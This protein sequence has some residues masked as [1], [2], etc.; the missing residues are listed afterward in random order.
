[1]SF[2][3]VIL[4]D[5][6]YATVAGRPLTGSKI[7]HG[8]KLPDQKPI[9]DFV[10]WLDLV[11]GIPEVEAV[12]W[13]QYTPYWNDGEA[14]TFQVGEIY[15]KLTGDLED[16]GE[17]EDGWRHSCD[18]QDSEYSPVPEALLAAAEGA[19]EALEEMSYQETKKYYTALEQAFGDH[20]EVTATR[21]GFAIEEYE[22]E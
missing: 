6:D 1:M 15:V 9:E 13:S 16:A 8:R 18:L 20:T 4:V 12:K 3:D 10:A 22:H 21:E 11:L 17:E 14:C 2:G 19:H 5:D 7:T